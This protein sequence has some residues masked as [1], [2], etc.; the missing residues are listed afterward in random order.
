MARQTSRLAAGRADT[1]VPGAVVEVVLEQRTDTVFSVCRKVRS[2]PASAA[3][4][5]AAM[6]EAGTVTIAPPGRA[7]RPLVARRRALVCCW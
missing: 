6:W 5:A 2:S 7:S 1:A 3:C 4:L